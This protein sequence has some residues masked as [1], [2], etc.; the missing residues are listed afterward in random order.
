MLLRLEDI[1]KVY[2]N[3]GIQV[4]ALKHVDLEIDEGE[5]VAIMGARI[6]RNL[7]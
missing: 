2:Q 1:S 7:S 3:N 5:C 6:S 4:E